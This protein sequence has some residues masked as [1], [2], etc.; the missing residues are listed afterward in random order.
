MKLRHVFFVV[1]L[2]TLYS[3]P[4]FSQVIC[5]DKISATPVSEVI[6]RDNSGK[7]LTITDGNG[8]IQ[9]PKS[10]DTLY[11]SHIGYAE[12]ELGL[13]LESDTIWLTPL[14]YELPDVAITARKGEY[15]YQ[16]LHTLTRTYQYIDSIP[17]YF[18]E[19][20]TDFYFP[21][22]GQK[23]AYNL[24]SSRAY[25]N[26]EYIAIAGTESGAVSMQKNGITN[27]LANGCIPLPKE[28]SIVANTE[29]SSSMPCFLIK[30]NNGV[31]G[32][33][34]R[35]EQGSLEV[36]LDMLFPKTEKEQSFM[37]R[38]NTI[39]RKQV[40]YYFSSH[41]DETTMSR[42]GF[43]LYQYLVSLETSYKKQSPV[44]ILNVFEVYVLSREKI[45][46]QEFRTVKSS[47][48]YGAVSSSHNINHPEWQEIT[49][50]IPSLPKVVQE[51]LGNTLLLLPE[52]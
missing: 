34:K 27:I 43:D 50:S 37:G 24:H 48:S 35:K 30:M 20:I 4:S 32:S 45:T 28:Y 31:A 9:I 40:L 18:T 16:V 13:P 29:D 11:L 2:Y 44:P 19:T 15:D 6:V 12:Y 10:T 17:V 47:R 41:I 33:I 52:D 7:F 38:T 49:S 36:K 3:I 46:R 39:K 51:A 25:R 42:D 21:K 8:N 23:L 22:K 1:F 14:T 26:K 5:V